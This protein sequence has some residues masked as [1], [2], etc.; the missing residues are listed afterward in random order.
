MKLQE[1]N[2]DELVEAAD[3]KDLNEIKE[4]TRLLEYKI[5]IQNTR[6]AKLLSSLEKM[7]ETNIQLVMTIEEMLYVVSQKEQE[8]QQEINVEIAN[9]KIN[10]WEKLN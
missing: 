5:D 10:N 8:N 9:P 4:K 6:I 2:T 3:E 7:T 1:N